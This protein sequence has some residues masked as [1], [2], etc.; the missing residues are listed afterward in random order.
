MGLF[1]LGKKDA[2]GKQRRIEHRGKYLR[3]SRTGGV[4]L[5]AQ[6]RAAG[7]N[8]TANTRRGVRASVTPAKNTQ[9]ALQNGRFILRGRYGKGPTKLNLSKSGAS[10]STRN[11]LGSFNWFRPNRS[12]AKVFGVQI[13]GQK[14]AQLQMV[15]MVF[16]A[17]VGGVQLLFVVIGGLLRGAVALGQWLIDHARALPRRWRNAR[18]Q[19]QRRKVDPAVSQAIRRLDADGL[20]AAVALAVGLWGRGETLDEGWRRIQ[21]RVT[22]NR[23]FEALPRSPERFEAVAAELERCR[24]AVHPAQDAHRIVLALLAE[25]AAQGVD[26]E[27]RAALLFDVD[28]LALARGPRTVLQEELLEIF[29]D[30]AQ[31]RLEPASPVDGK[32]GQRSQPRQAP[33][34]PQG[35]IDLN[36]ASI[37]ELQAIPH[38]GP[39]RAAAIAAMRPIQRIEQLEAIDG[40]GPQRLREIAAHARL[41]DSTKPVE[42]RVEK[43]G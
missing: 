33:E 38:V 28:D 16:A 25:K 34:T 41:N 5:R 31:L 24:A 6:A 22:Q 12:S 17:L 8:L 21:R 30:H 1:N 42:N 36:T 3:A 14:A 20:S 13:R 9:V 4:A 29:A 26:G 19:R 18:L 37:E 2:Y 11:R 27:R 43:V 10:V 32:Q 7:V 35:P 39:E 23:G 15:Y 40:I